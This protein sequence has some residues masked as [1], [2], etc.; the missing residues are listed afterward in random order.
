MGPKKKHTLSNPSEEIVTLTA[1][2]ISR[3]LPKVLKEV[4]NIQPSAETTPGKKK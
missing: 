3:R 1:D 4:C 2:K